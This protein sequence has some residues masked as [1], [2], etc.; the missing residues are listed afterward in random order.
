M[1]PP[2][3]TLQKRG[4]HGC[5]ETLNLYVRGLPFA[6]RLAHAATAAFLQVR[7][8]AMAAN[9]PRSHARRRGPRPA[10]GFLS[11]STHGG[12]DPATMKF[13]L[14]ALFIALLAF[15]VSRFIMRDRQ[16]SA[17]AAPAKLT[18]SK[19]SFSTAPMPPFSWPTRP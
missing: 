15:G 9:W 17:A 3:A 16:A 10:L 7:R 2:R 12:C 11:I 13:Y 8:P 18:G 19:K 14:F 5:H 4:A 1:V 6:Q